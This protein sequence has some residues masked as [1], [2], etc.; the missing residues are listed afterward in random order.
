MD[1]REQLGLTY[2]FISHDLG[3]V[4]HLSDRVVIMYLG[5]IVEQAGVGA[6]F[7]RPNHPYTRALL[8]EIPRI[9]ARHHRFSA[10]RGELPSPA[11]PPTGCHF[12]PR[13]PYAMPRCS[14]ER[15]AL[16]E[17]APGHHS[18]CHLNDMA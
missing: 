1:L 13:C 10:L 12:H 3:V 18:A 5:R 14:V 11:A 6:V 15:P 7:S 16:C 8:A 17:V 4:E 9:E 2:L